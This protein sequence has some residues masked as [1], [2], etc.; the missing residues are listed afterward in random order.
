MHLELGVGLFIVMLAL[1]ALR[2]PIALS[3]IVTGCFGFAYLTSWDALLSHMK[4]MPFSRA[5][6]YSLSVIPMF[7]LMGLF[8]ANGGLSRA[9]YRAARAWFGHFRG[10]LAIATIGGCA[11]FGAICGSS[12]ATGATM[13][14][15]ALPEMR[16]YGY[17]DSLSTGCLAVGGTLGILIPPSIIL[18]I[19]GLITELPIGDLFVAAFIP[20]LIA[21]IGY[22][23]AI[24]ILV[25][26]RPHAGPAAERESWSVRLRSL[27][28]VWPVVVIFLIVIGGLY[29]GVFTPTEGAAV[30]TV[31][32]ALFASVFGELRWPKIKQSLLETAGITGM[33]FM[34]LI[35]AEIYSSFLALS[36]IPQQLADWI[37]GRGFGPYTVLVT[38]IAI[39][40]LLG[41]VMDEIGMILLTVPVF[42]PIVMGL[43]FGMN[44]AAQGIWFGILLLNVVEIGLILPPIGLNVFVINA[45]AKDVPLAQTY[46]GIFPFFYSDLVR[47]AIVV[48]VPGTCTWLLKL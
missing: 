8:A 30:G 45:M 42:Y 5:A 2:M 27:N 47:I 32:T 18:V 29:V 46:R 25:R 33:I 1:I 35:A 22:M 23:I 37:E 26:V 11:A 36:Q 24:M 17:S 4:D 20:G 10:G 19:V 38:I 3:M 9:A 43:D 41:A 13:A 6:N 15:A 16:R 34:I 7:V 39:Y 21:T 14:T 48:L 44:P 40:I 28:A 31:A 12:V